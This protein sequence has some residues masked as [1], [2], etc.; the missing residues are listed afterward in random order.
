MHMCQWGTTAI[1]IESTLEDAICEARDI[2]SDGDWW[3]SSGRTR[4][5][6]HDDC[7]DDLASFPGTA[8]Y[9]WQC[10]FKLIFCPR[11]MAHTPSNCWSLDVC[12]W[13]NFAV[14]FLLFYLISLLFVGRQRVFLSLALNMLSKETIKYA[15][16]FISIRRKMFSLSSLHIY[17]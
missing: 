8:H 11:L 6:A 4:A 10:L 3:V 13:Y 17:D 5:R 1:P 12:V 14:F 15:F 9:P 7:P 2:G 16:I